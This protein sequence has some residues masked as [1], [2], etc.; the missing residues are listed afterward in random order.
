VI[1]LGGLARARLD[2]RRQDQW[3]IEWALID[4]QGR[5]TG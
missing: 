5:R 3:D 2:L 1:L 4:P